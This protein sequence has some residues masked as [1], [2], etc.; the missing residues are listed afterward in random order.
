MYQTTE[1]RKQLSGL[2]Q[3]N[4]LRPAVRKQSFKSPA[5][6]ANACLKP[7]QVPSGFIAVF[8]NSSP[9]NEKQAQN[10]REFSVLLLLFFP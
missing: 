1:F 2:A 8:L 4:Y 7:R 9:L 5:T 3:Q 10:W 6:T